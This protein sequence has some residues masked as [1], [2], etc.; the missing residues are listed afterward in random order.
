MLPQVKARNGGRHGAGVL[1]KILRRRVCLSVPRAT[2]LSVRAPSGF[3][4]EGPF[5][6]VEKKG[7][8][9]EQYLR[10]FR[11]GGVEDLTETYGSL[12]NAAIVTL[13][14]ELAGSQAAVKELCRRG[15]TVS[16]GERHELLLVVDTG[17]LGPVESE[18]FF[19]AGHSVANLSQAEEAVQSGASFI[20]HLFNAMLP[21]SSLQ[22]PLLTPE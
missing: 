4:L 13:A 8:H 18:F 5:I 2:L 16:L 19:I 9:P 3:H 10:S 1:G 7:A 12:D 22:A 21:V 6:S 17:P 15:I 11:S 20:T 14:P